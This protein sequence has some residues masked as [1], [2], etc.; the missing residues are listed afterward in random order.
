MSEPEIHRA[1]DAEV[2]MSDGVKKNLSDFW[3]VKP[4]VLIFLRYFGCPFCRE[5]V[6]QLIQKKENFDSSGL[7][8]VL[9]STESPATAEP[10]RKHF[11]VPFPVICDPGK[12]LHRAYGL[13]GGSMFQVFSPEVFL[14]GLRALGRGYF[15][16]LPEGDPF[17]LPGL[18]I[19]NTEG[20]ICFSCYSRDPSDYPSVERILS[21]A[22][23]A[24][25]G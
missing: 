2:L 3:S 19:I 7:Q 20:Q 1:P 16:G 18:F 22:Q 24:H 17:Q 9:V 8:P 10:F 23:K 21:A 13:K 6:A 4:I 5:Q 14:K 11:G 12:T 25:V 15:P